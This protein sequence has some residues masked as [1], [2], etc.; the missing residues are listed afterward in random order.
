[1]SINVN[2]QVESV[3][4]LEEFD[5]LVERIK[6]SHPLKYAQRLESGDL[7]KQR[8]L[9]G[10]I[11]TEP[12]SIKSLSKSKLIALAEEKGIELTGKE[13]KEELVEKIEALN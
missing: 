8:A 6:V 1:M 4:T 5:A 10:E 2:N 9:L 13:S 7:A 12:E 11:K 3:Q